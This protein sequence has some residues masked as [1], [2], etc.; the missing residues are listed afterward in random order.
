M[1]STDEPEKQV[2]HSFP[3]ADNDRLSGS[4]VRVSASGNTVRR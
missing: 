1:K 2:I 4:F 3:R